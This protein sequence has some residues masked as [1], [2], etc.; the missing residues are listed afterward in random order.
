MLTG[1]DTFASTSFAVFVVVLVVM[2]RGDATTLDSA[3]VEEYVFFSS[4]L[5]MVEVYVFLSPLTDVF[6]APLT[7]L[8]EPI[9]DDTGVN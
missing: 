1:E 5:E 9:I 2:P 3:T 6:V 4:R 7:S 8:V